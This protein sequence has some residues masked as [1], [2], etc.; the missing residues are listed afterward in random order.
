MAPGHWDWPVVEGLAQHRCPHSR[1][2]EGRYEAPKV[3]GVGSVTVVLVKSEFG[4]SVV[5]RLERDPIA[6]RRT[7]FQTVGME[8]ASGDVER[9]SRPLPLNVA[10]I[11]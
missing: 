5:D 1:R 9:R 3:N 6:V 2:Y 10:L 8:R 11:R 7:S 4:Q